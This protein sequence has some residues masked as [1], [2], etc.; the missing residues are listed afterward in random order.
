MEPYAVIEDSLMGL[1][2]ARRA[3]MAVIAL[4]GTAEREALSAQADLVVD[5][6]RELSPEGIRELIDRTG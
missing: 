4:T 3:G 6:L 5:S 1:E 2:A